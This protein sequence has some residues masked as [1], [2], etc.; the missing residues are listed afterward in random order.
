MAN[1]WL[2][3]PLEDYER[4]MN[5][6]EV[7]QLSVLSEL[8]AEAITLCRPASV[9]VLGIA[10]GNG[11]EH[12]DTQVTKRVVGLDVNPA[13]LEAVSRRHSSACQLELHCAD[14]AED[15]V[16]LEPV[17]LVHVALVFEHAGAGRCLDNALSLVAP[18]GALSV[19]L[20]LPSEIEQGVSTTAVASIQKLRADFSFIDPTWLKETLEERGFQ[21][22]RDTRRSLLAGKAFW[23]GVFRR[24]IL[25]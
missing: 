7:Q 21:L 14:L 17:A 13:Y 1:P 22:V 11:L 6:A 8:F 3:V 23:M 12:I 9:A 25:R 16:E 24:R 4:H 10:G 15:V 18:N 2:G 20:Q 19:V 5:S